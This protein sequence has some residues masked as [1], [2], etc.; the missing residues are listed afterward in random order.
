PVHEQARQELGPARVD[1][2]HSLEHLA[3]DDLDVLVVDEH[4]LRAVDLLDLLGQVDLHRPWAKH[5]QQLVRIDGA[6]GELLA[7]LDVVAVLLAQLHPL[8]DLVV[9]D[10]VAAVVRHDDDLP[11]PVSLFDANPAGGLRDRGL[12]LGDPRLEDLLHPGQTLGDVLTGDTT[13]VERPHRQLRARLADGLRGDDAD[14]LAHVDQ[15]AGRQGPT[16]AGGA[17]TELRLAGEDA[18]HPY[19]LDAGLDDLVDQD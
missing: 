2:R 12:A 7:D 16:V 8:G 18:A 11:R 19:R 13:G 17:D 10:L 4:A 5:A 3:N 14:R 6:L 1:D 15:L 9:G